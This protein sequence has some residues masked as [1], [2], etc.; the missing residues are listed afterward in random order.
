MSYSINPEI[1]YYIRNQN[2]VLIN[3]TLSVILL[4]I[5]LILLVHRRLL[6]DTLKLARKLL[7]IKP[8]IDNE[9]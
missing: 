5:M 1:I 6:N 9:N 2:S 8:V 7:Y 4:I 3:N